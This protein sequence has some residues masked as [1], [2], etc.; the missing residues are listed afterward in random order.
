LAVNSAYKITGMLDSYHGRP[1]LTCFLPQPIIRERRS[2]GSSLDRAV[3][4]VR[5]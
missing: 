4:H 3:D 5:F 1:F 2:S